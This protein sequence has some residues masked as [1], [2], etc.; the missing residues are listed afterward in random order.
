MESKCVR[1]P[2]AEKASTKT[3]GT[4]CGNA[5]SKIGDPMIT[6]RKQIATVK[7]KAITG[8]LVQ[9]DKQE[10]IARNPPAMNQLPI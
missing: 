6:N 2:I 5:L 10:P 1:K 4:H 3:C 7:I 8:F 9:A